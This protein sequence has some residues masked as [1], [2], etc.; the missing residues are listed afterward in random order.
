MTD[1]QGNARNL[2]KL[3]LVPETARPS[4]LLAPDRVLEHV[5]ESLATL[6]FEDAV[7]QAF[8]FSSL[9]LPGEPDL[10]RR[11]TRA[12]AVPEGGGGEGAAA[13]APVADEEGEDRGDFWRMLRR[14]Y[15]QLIDRPWQP[16]RHL[17]PPRWTADDHQVSF[18][19]ILDGQAPPPSVAVT[20]Q[21]AKEGSHRGCW[22]VDT[23]VLR[24][25]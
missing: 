23:V 20:L 1:G 24:E 22:L 25:S 6:P 15:A 9:V 17:A 21:R 19:V 18:L 2:D 8:R 14:S 16:L 4:A 12:A 11:W 13:A 10:R 7:E 5:L 3:S